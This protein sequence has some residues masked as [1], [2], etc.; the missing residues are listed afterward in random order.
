VILP[1]AENESDANRALTCLLLRST[2]LM[3]IKEEKIQ[4]PIATNIA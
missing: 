2:K 4:K 3:K 1:S